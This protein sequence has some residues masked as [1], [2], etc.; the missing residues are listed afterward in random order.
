MPIR[1]AEFAQRLEQRGL[2]A[3]LD[4]DDKRKPVLGIAGFL[5]HGVEVDVADL[6]SAVAMA[7]R[8]PG[9]SLTTKR[10]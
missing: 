8:M 3:G 9:R 5:Q 4:R 7:A 1:V 2:F 10:R 6:A